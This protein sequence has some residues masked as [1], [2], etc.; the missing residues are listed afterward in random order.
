MLTYGLEFCE[1]FILTNTEPQ[2]EIRV[3][4]E[5]E[6]RSLSLHSL[7]SIF[8]FM[9]KSCVLREKIIVTYHCLFASCHGRL[10][11]TQELRGKSP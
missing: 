8:V 9:N 2:A 5:T 3:G 4:Y 10:I 7:T 11:A 6:T 1:Y